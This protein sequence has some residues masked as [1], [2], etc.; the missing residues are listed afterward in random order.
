MIGCAMRHD[1]HDLWTARKLGVWRLSAL[2]RVNQC[3]ANIVSQCAELQEL[4][5][6]DANA[7]R[8]YR[9]S[10][11]ELEAEMNRGF[12]DLIETAESRAHLR[13]TKARKVREREN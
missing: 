2:Y 10:V 9:L 12:A 6:L 3:F 7:A 5:I 13:L 4:K 8:R 1:V 11:Q